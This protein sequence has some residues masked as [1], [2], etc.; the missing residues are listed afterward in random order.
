MYAFETQSINY[1]LLNK[2]IYLNKLENNITPYCVAVSGNS[3]FSKL[4]IP[5]FIPG[6][7]RS[8]FGEENLKNMKKHYSIF[9]TKDEIMEIIRWI[10]AERKLIFN[11]KRS[12]EEGAKR[13]D[14]LELL[15]HK[16]ILD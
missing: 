4:Y 9:L 13:E 8:Q 15:E 6:G 3:G 2:N 14:F 5:K 16:L 11:G 7:N 1:Y 12:A 10:K